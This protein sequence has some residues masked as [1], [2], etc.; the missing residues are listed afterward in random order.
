M[1]HTAAILAVVSLLALSGQP[2][3]AQGNMLKQLEARFSA[4]DKDHDGK[5]SKSEATAGMPRV[6]LYFEKID[7]DNTGFIT[8]T[9]I[10]AFMAQ[11]KK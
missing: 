9:Q 1:R 4:A 6:A 3:L 11:Q 10:E 7:A 5:L 2:A 8:L